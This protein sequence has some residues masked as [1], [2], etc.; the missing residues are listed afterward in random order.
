M[1]PDVLVFA[2]LFAIASCAEDSELPRASGAGACTDGASVGR[3]ELEAGAVLC[4]HQ[5][6]VA[7]IRPGDDF[8]MKLRVLT[9][10]DVDVCFEDDDAEPHEVWIAGQRVVAQRGCVPVTL[11][12]IDHDVRLVHWLRDAT[13]KDPTVDV[14]HT[15]WTAPKAGQRGKLLLTS[16]ACRGCKLTSPWPKLGEAFYGRTL[17]LNGYTGDYTGATITGTCSSGQE[18][19]ALGFDSDSH[20]DDADV[21]F[22]SARC[23]VGTWNS[24][25]TSAQRAHLRCKGA[26]PPL[27]ATLL[28]QGDLRSA[29]VHTTGELGAFEADLAGVDFTELVD[30]HVS[31]GNSRLD[32]AAYVDFVAHRSHVTSSTVVLAPDANLTGLTLEPGAGIEPFTLEWPKDAQG[33]LSMSG[34]VFTNATLRNITL[35]CLEGAVGNLDGAHFDG[36]T[37]ENVTFSWCSLNGSTFHGAKLRN[38]VARNAF[39]QK[40]TL[41]S[42]DV[43]SL[44]LTL[45]TLSGATLTSAPLKPMKHLVARGL[46][47]V[48]LTADGLTV[49]PTPTEAPA[50]F[51]HATLK[52]SSFDGAELEHAN[53]KHATLENTHFTG[54]HLEGAD[55]SEIQGALATFDGAYLVPSRANVRATLANATIDA[56][57]FKGAHLTTAI[58]TG[59]RL[60]GGNFDTAGLIGADLTDTPMPP[61]LVTLRDG[62]RGVPCKMTLT[63]VQQDATTICPDGSAGPCAGARWLPIGAVTC[64]AG[65]KAPGFA[66]TKDCDCQSTFCGAGGTCK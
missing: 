32:F 28:L 46:V 13:E 17:T 24:A 49:D 14:I 58:V 2:S 25:T 26:A 36:A 21:T 44:D 29:H 56:P 54:A 16:N 9:P 41:T 39:F 10:G 43:D 33:R 42:L 31:I 52:K 63:A 57:S 3:P 64:P 38:V 22:S 27:P 66:C 40:S 47:A 6:L 60:C 4:E 5:T 20:F 45:A 62:A 65:G 8:A 50:D 7:A 30:H 11:G 35:P 37:L 18:L 53:F 51:D 61:D 34:A 15:R 1:K 23:D 55:F 59:A 19:C 48:G 12:A